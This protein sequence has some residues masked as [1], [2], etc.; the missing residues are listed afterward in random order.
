MGG[1]ITTGAYVGKGVAF[2]TPFPALP[3]WANAL[4]SGFDDE[5][6]VGAF[7]EGVMFAIPGFFGWAFNNWHSVGVNAATHSTQGEWVIGG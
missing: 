1:G 3:A 7:S 6:P 5:R 4:T 2:E